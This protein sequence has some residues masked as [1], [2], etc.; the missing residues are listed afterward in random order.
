[1]VSKY[2]IDLGTSNFREFIEK[3]NLYIDKTLF[4]EHIID[5]PSKVLLFTRPRRMGKTLNLD[6]LRNFVDPQVTDAKELFKG[7]NIEKSHVYEKMGSHP[8]IWLSFRDFTLNDKYEIYLKVIR[9]TIKKYIPDEKISIE[10]KNILDDRSL[11]SLSG[12]KFLTEN[13]YKVTGKRSYVI[14]DEY[15]KLVMDSAPK[16]KEA[17]ADALDFT[18]GIMG[19]VFK[20]NPHLEKGVI[21]GVNRIAQESMFSDLNNIVV[22]GVFQTS[23]FDTDFGFTDD[24]V[25]ELIEDKEELDAVRN[26]YNGFRIGESKIYF[27][28]SVMGYLNAGK[29][30]TYWGKSGSM[31]LIKN[32]LTNDRIDAISKIISNGGIRESVGDRLSMEDLNS[33]NRSAAFYSLLVQTGYLTHDRTDLDRGKYDSPSNIF[34]LSCPN[35]E[36]QKVWKEWILDK[37]YATN[38]YNIINAFDYGDNLAIFQGRFRELLN[39]KLSYFDFEKDEPEKTYH[40]YVLGLLAASGYKVK[41][42]KESG[43]GRYDIVLE[44]D[45]KTMIFEFKRLKAKPI[46]GSINAKLPKV[47]KSAIQ[48]IRDKNYS[49][50]IKTDKPIILVGIGFCGK[51]N[52]VTAEKL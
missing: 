2:R 21:T 14:M 50:E 12:L 34:L 35:V 29:F 24:E 5:N 20:D 19:P 25:S 31:D 22:D 44:L 30:G 27:A 39:N 11:K 49:A 18:K 41:S 46:F 26:W 52:W 33:K 40:V 42:N 28:Y 47:A 51:S 17:L 6:T 16:R 23:E 32:N 7:L 8:V 4:I 45:D 13:I 3:G 37:I 9:D 10:L 43:F 48:Q 15:D 36:L 38:F 1:M